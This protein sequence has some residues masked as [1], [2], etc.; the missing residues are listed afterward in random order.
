MKDEDGDP[1]PLRALAWHV[2]GVPF[3]LAGVAVE[4]LAS[5]GWLFGVR[6][7]FWFRSM[8]IREKAAK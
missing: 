1:L 3:G 2:V 8:D 5:S 4:A 6:D 7:R